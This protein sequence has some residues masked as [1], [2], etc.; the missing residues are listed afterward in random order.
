MPE[1]AISFYV[2]IALGT[3]Y[4]EIQRIIVF[5]GYDK[6]L[7]FGWNIMSLEFRP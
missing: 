2:D 7:S 6:F 1:I 3:I 4:R 5:S